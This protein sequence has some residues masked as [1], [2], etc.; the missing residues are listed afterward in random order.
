[1]IHVDLYQIIREFAGTSIS[2]RTLAQIKLYKKIVEA[3]KFVEVGEY[4]FRVERE[5]SCDHKCGGIFC[6]PINMF[7]MIGLK[8]KLQYEIIKTKE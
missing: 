5:C 1:M 4:V 7:H 3:A 2:N 8:A 6:E